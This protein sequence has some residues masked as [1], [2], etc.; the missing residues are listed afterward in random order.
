MTEPKRPPMQ[1]SAEQSFLNWLDKANPNKWQYEHAIYLTAYA[2]GRASLLHAHPLQVINPG[3]G[4]DLDAMVE[5]A[6][7]AQMEADC[8]V[9]ARLQDDC[10]D[11]EYQALVDASAAIRAAFAERQKG[12]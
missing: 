10:D 11:I 4:F 6:R 9:M 12:G 8:A 1:P 5:A 3:R 2:D 7:G